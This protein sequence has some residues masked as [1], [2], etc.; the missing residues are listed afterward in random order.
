MGFS[1]RQAVALR[2][3]HPTLLQVRFLRKPV[4]RILVVQPNVLTRAR[5]RGFRCRLQLWREAEA[6]RYRCDILGVLLGIMYND[7]VAGETACLQTK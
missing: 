1:G 5:C 4:N 6:R 7:L 2:W 3:S